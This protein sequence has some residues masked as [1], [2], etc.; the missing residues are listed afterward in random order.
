MATTRTPV[1]K[2]DDHE[3]YGYQAGTHLMTS[4][5]T[6]KNFNGTATAV[7]AMTYDSAERVTTQTDPN[8]HTTHFTYGPDGGLSAGQTLVADP[9]GHKCSTPTRT[10]C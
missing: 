8:S 9:S 10:A 6:A 3:R 5:R 7:T 2:D 4:V 1:L